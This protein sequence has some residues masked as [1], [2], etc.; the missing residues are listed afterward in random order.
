MA[1]VHDLSIN[2][3]TMPTPALDGVTISTEKIWSA[4][5]G[6]TGSGKMVGT[7]IARKTTIKIKWPPMSYQQAALIEQA[8][9]DGDFVPV[10]YTDM[11]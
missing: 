6:R 11:R 1:N 2:G 5:T 7:V 10:S 3:V 4:D 9:S 8:V